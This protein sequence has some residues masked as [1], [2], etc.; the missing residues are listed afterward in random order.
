MYIYKLHMQTQIHYFFLVCSAA[1]GH[2]VLHDAV[3]PH[4]QNGE[5]VWC[6]ALQGGTQWRGAPLPDGMKLWFKHPL[7]PRP[8]NFTTTLEHPL[9]PSP[10]Q[11]FCTV[12]SCVPALLCSLSFHHPFCQRVTQLEDKGHLY[13]F[14]KEENPI[15]FTPFEYIS[16]LYY[17][18]IFVVVFFCLD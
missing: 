12:S 15:G 18:I 11:T 2:G 1:P 5:E 8:C 13:T 6:L 9:L 10:P 4:P 17:F 16:S 7:L 14:G 3:P